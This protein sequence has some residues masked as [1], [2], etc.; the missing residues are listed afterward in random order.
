MFYTGKKTRA[1]A[2]SGGTTLLCRGFLL[3][4]GKVHRQSTPRKVDQARA[5]Q[6]ALPCGGRTVDSSKQPYGFFV[7][8]D[9]HDDKERCYKGTKVW[10]GIIRDAWTG[11]EANW[12]ET[13]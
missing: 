11:M 2:G 7:C 9:K 3:W 13:W 10:H 6:S 8:D 5:G 1:A 4:M 12:G